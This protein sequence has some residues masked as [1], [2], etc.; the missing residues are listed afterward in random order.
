MPT[1]KEIQ[2]MNLA[3]ALKMP[4]IPI[5]LKCPHCNEPINCTVQISRMEFVVGYPKSQRDLLD[6]VRKKRQR[7]KFTQ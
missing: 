2:A 3:R 1:F 7:G 6:E 5:V 4:V